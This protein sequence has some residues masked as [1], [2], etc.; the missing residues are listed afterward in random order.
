ML[1][2]SGGFTYRITLQINFACV[3]NMSYDFII[4]DHVTVGCQCEEVWGGIAA[5]DNASVKQFRREFAV[6]THH[7]AV[8]FDVKGGIL[9]G[10][11]PFIETLVKDNHVLLTA[12][13]PLVFAQVK[14]VNVTV[15]LL[16]DILNFFL[17]LFD[18]LLALFDKI[19][20]LGFRRQA[21]Q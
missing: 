7:L 8:F 10:I 1:V 4:H 19:A 14:E 6:N 13:K 9:S 17:G 16:A 11:F 18:S 2:D 3:V 5:V 21:K 15:D 20:E 12:V